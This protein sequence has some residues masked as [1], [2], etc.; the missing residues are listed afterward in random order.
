[1]FSGVALVDVRPEHASSSTDFRPSLKSLYHNKVF[2]GSRHYFG[3]LPVAFGWFLQQ[4]CLRL[5]QNLMLILCS[6]KSVISVVK[7]SLKHN[8]TK[9]TKLNKTSFILT[10]DGTLIH[11]AYF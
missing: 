5:K 4:F 1:M 6:L 2:F 7:K 9:R 10:T 11:K 3:K 8:L